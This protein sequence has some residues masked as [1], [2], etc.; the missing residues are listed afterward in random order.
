[1]AVQD[2]KVKRNELL[3]QFYTS[4]FDEVLCDLGHTLLTFVD[5]E[6]RPVHELLVDLE[7]HRCVEFDGMLGQLGAS[8]PA[9]VLSSNYLKEGSSPTSWRVYARVRSF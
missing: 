4:H 8:S 6:I 7:Y 2:I 1:M 3:P 9:R 5:R